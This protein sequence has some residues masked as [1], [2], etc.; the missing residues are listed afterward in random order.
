MS[1]ALNSDDEYENANEEDAVE[2]KLPDVPHVFTMNDK[3]RLELM[4]PVAP[5]S[6]TTVLL[7]LRSPT[8]ADFWERPHTVLWCNREDAAR[9]RL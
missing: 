4:R 1:Q 9:W 2:E 7:L 3:D 5:G 6:T 8:S